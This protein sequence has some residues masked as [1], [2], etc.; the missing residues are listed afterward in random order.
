MQMKVERAGGAPKESEKESG[1]RPR[2]RG[3]HKC[4]LSGTQCKF[5]SRAT[6]QR[7]VIQTCQAS[8]CT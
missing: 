4:H 1:V 7:Q 3:Q 8:Q 2:L 6:S 5:I